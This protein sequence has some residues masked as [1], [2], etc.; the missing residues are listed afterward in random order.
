MADLLTEQLYG[1]GAF[2]AIGKFIVHGDGPHKRNVHLFAGVIAGD[3]PQGADGN[4]Q[5]WEC[6]II[7]IPRR[8]FRDDGRFNGHRIDQLLTGHFGDREMWEQPPY[9]EKNDV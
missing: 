5:M 3:A 9:W 2:R 6:E 7:V 1:E 4:H 8:K